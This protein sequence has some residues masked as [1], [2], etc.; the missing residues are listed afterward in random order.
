MQEGE[1]CVRDFSDHLSGGETT[2]SHLVL[3]VKA[4]NNDSFVDIMSSITAVGDAEL[5]GWTFADALV[6]AI[7]SVER[8]TEGFVDTSNLSA[9]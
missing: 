7:L 1:E 4:D 5:E 3:G 6:R 9:C 8:L 2:A